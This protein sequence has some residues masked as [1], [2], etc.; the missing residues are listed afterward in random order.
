MKEK[1]L[2]QLCILIR[3]IR[4]RDLALKRISFA[5]FFCHYHFS[6]DYHHYFWN[7]IQSLVTN[8]CI[9]FKCTV[10]LVHDFNFIMKIHSHFPLF[11]YNLPYHCWVY[12]TE[13][14]KNPRFKEYV[15][16]T[17]AQKSRIKFST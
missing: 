5:I 13:V 2:L 15:R 7:G 12:F 6:F 1:G 11:H 14:G 10:H 16:K 9:G 17:L 4:S 8:W 3:S